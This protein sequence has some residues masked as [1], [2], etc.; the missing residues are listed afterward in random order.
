MISIFTRKLEDVAFALT[1]ARMEVDTKPSSIFIVYWHGNRS[2]DGWVHY[3][4]ESEILSLLILLNV[5][6]LRFSV[7]I[8]ISK[9]EVRVTREL[10]LNNL[11]F[12]GLSVS[13]CWNSEGCVTVQV[14]WVVIDSIHEVRFCIE[15]FWPIRTQDMLDIIWKPCSDGVVVAD[16]WK[17]EKMK[18]FKRS[19]GRP[20]WK[21]SFNRYPYQYAHLNRCP[22][23]YRYH[24][25]F[26]KPIPIL[27][28][29]KRIHRY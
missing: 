16:I 28:R 3:V 11:N 9:R 15:D 17:Q 5:V 4:M 27:L 22:Y 12:Q 2:C 10:T 29:S 25:H 19:S 8:V 7:A 6:F 21:F 1:R 13:S 24:S 14:L 18:I 20:I 23:R 26:F